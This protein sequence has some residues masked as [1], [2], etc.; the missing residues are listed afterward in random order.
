MKKLFKCFLVIF[1]FLA[2][3]TPENSKID[4]GL[5]TGI[6][7]SAPCWQNLT[8]GISTDKDVEHFLDNLSMTEWPSRR[9]FDYESG[10]RS[11]RLA[12]TTSNE[13]VGAVLDLNIENER[14]TFVESFHPGMFK[15]K[16]IVDAFGPPEYFKALLAVG[17]DGDFYNLEVYYP[18]RGIAFQVSVNQKERGYIRPSMK[19]DTVQYFVP[20]DL[21]TYL[22]TIY[23]CD[24]G[25]EGA[26]INAKK[27]ILFVQSWSGFGKINV[28]QTK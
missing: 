20:G 19:I 13:D 14:L 4:S 23:S 2:A 16:G 26:L 18:Q 6:P 17:P 15:L 8:P 25:Q 12:D 28:I 24:L 22:T 10:C 9:T 1:L 11:T 21:L 3:C 7:C 5:F 27:D